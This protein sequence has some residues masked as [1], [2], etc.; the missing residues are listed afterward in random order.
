[1]PPPKLYIQHIRLNGIVER[2]QARERNGQVYILL[3]DAQDIFGNARR[4]QYNRV[5]VPFM[6]DEND[7][8]IEPPRI[9]YYE[10][11][12]LDVVVGPG[13]EETP[14]LTSSVPINIPSPQS[15]A[16][17]TPASSFTSS[18]ASPRSL[19]PISVAPLSIVRPSLTAALSPVSETTNKTT[20][21]DGAATPNLRG[22][23]A[24]VDS[25]SSKS[26]KIE[27]R[28]PIEL[29]P[30][31]DIALNE[32][33]RPGDTDKSSQG[34]SNGIHP[35][36][37]STE[38]IASEPLFRTAQTVHTMPIA[39]LDE[40]EDT[41]QQPSTPP[42]QQQQYED[43]ASPTGVRKSSVYIADGS[44]Q[45]VTSYNSH[46]LPPL[47]GQPMEAYA[48]QYQ[49][50]QQYQHQ[51]Q[52]QPYQLYQQPYRQQ[53]QQHQQHQQQY[54]PPPHPLSVATSPPIPPR[55]QSIASSSSISTQP[56]HR[57]SIAH[58]PQA[59]DPE[60]RALLASS[61]TA[62]SF[63]TQ[64]P[65]E[66]FSHHQNPPGQLERMSLR[67]PAETETNSENDTTVKDLK[68]KLRRAQDQTLAYAKMN[69]ALARESL[70]MSAKIMNRATL[71]QNKVQA[72]LTQNHEPHEN[73]VARLF[74]VLPVLILDQSNPAKLVPASDQRKFRLHFLC[75]CGH[76]TR[77]LRSSG[78][79]SIHFVEHEGYEIEHPV[80]FFEKY[81]AFIRSLSHMLRKGVNCGSVS[82]SPLLS[83][84]QQAQQQNDAN[85]AYHGNP[86]GQEILKNQ[87][88]DTRLTETIDYLDSLDPMDSPDN[89]GSMQ[90]LVEYF[91]GTNIRQLQTYIRI[92]PQDLLSLAG[93]YKIVTSRGHVKW[94]CEEHYRS[95]IHHQNE[96]L[97]QQELSGLGGQYD[98]RTGRAAVQL[99][100]AQDANQLYKIMSKAHNL[101]ELNVG[102]KW[103]FNESD[104]Q[105]FV[106]AIQ[107]S[108]IRTLVLDGGKQKSESTSR[109]LVTFGKKYDP[110][111][112]IIYGSKIGT[113]RLINIPSLLLKI[114][115][116]QP[117]PLSQAYGIKALHLENVGSLDFSAAEKSGN[118]ISTSLSIGHGAGRNPSLTFL[119]NL[120]TNFRALAELS[121]PGMGIR[122]EGIG[123][124]TEQTHLRK[125][126]RSINLYNNGISPVGGRLLAAF[127]TREKALVQLDLGMNEIGDET[128]AFIIDALGPNLSLLNL[129]STGFRDS[130]A[131]ALDRM[132]ENY[133]PSW[134]LEPQLEYLN[135]A[136]NGWT[137]SSIQSLGRI[138]MQLRLEIPPP[139]SPSISAPLPRKHDKPGQLEMGPAESFLVVNSMIRTS[140]M[141]PSIDK[142]WYQQTDFL[143]GH[144]ALTAIKESYTLPSMKAQESIATNSK[145]KV[146]QLSDAGLT[147]SAARYLI[148]LLDVNVLTKLDLR[149]CIRLFKPREILRI[150][151]RIYPNSSYM[152]EGGESMQQQRQDVPQAPR[153]YGIAGTPQNYLRFIHLNAT[154]VDDH[155][156]RILAQ[157]LES[158]PCCIERLDIGSNCLTHQGITMI[159]NALCQNTSL[160]HLN[161]G[162][163]FDALNV[164]Y[165]SA[166]ATLARVTREAFL[167]FMMTNKT[168][169]I[170]YFISADI[171]VVARGLKS[172]SSIRSLA[173]DRLEG[174]LNDVEAFV[175]ALAVNQTLM[176]FKVYD[177]R[178]TPFLEAFYGNGQQQQQQQQYQQHQQPAY[179]SNPRYQY[180]QPQQQQQSIQY[181][182][183]FKDFKQEA[184]KA[185]ENGI[186]LNDTLIELQWPEMFDRMQ[187]WTERLEGVLARNIAKLS[188]GAGNNND[189]GH[190]GAKER[191]MFQHSG[192]VT[193]GLSVLSTSS[194][195]SNGSNTSSNSSLSSMSSS[196]AYL[197]DKSLSRSQSGFAP[198]HAQ[199]QKQQQQQQP[200]T[201]RIEAETHIMQRFKK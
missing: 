57:P 180:Q 120:L 156:A 72:V 78:L 103:S 87:I 113:L 116:K 50:Q 10:D 125:T 97:F 68:M 20:N 158:K 140:H 130:A 151:A 145:L 79:N 196:N 136:T 99:R 160:Q 58:A 21:T 36:G 45:P 189:A 37:V 114:S 69:H 126:L 91:D 129:E 89:N 174:S 65:F 131:K 183:P 4:F 101:Q 108:K 100:S 107:D 30:S 135:L 172:N 137:T 163:N 13:S 80:E 95:T 33:T 161:L 90:D 39:L 139:S 110:L 132:I 146:L 67:L 123:L 154:G 51:Y 197:R 182:D 187:P 71:I 193:R 92:P 166:A 82:I 88:L 152:Q 76:H 142:P 77:P 179:P 59:L 86:V 201:I 176:R 165:P 164:V 162:Q 66:S 27:Q 35:R 199:K 150:L 188:S 63:T 178:Q 46:P 109:K 44:Y 12:I 194:T 31:L 75:E 60:G 38:S 29:G 73:P 143:N 111:L 48:A 141:A 173:F 9:A 169:Q 157:S 149:R 104:L 93:L 186:T 119:K 96:L 1:M 195:L 81:G 170:L 56:F 8:R 61:P 190:E 43:P 118:Y 24:S 112:R 3:Q 7:R 155:V 84:P 11:C 198:A 62:S 144:L 85:S 49:L 121:L 74:I 83:L 26:L 47:P 153:P 25:I 159:L 128:L 23:T 134:K 168:L 200:R 191:G 184:I 40:Y 2:I 175:R 94:V 102:L 122:D 53:H 41:T 19:S 5:G 185:I 98:L 55:P 18:V 192:R 14:A 15:T 127:L 70:Q 64:Q 181:V 17:I 124:I 106:Q 34:I 171:E 54:L 22:R 133:S 52:Q 138:I 115:T 105:R 32:N 16:P 147:E 42:P 167:R 177:N 148:G 28:S 117:Q 6:T